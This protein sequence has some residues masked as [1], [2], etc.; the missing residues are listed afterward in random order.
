MPIFKYTALKNNR[1]F[2]DGVV[3]ALDY[4]EARNKIVNLGFTPT[5]VYSE[6]FIDDNV[7]KDIEPSQGDVKRLSLS[8]KISFTSELQT[9]LSSNI[10]ILE[11]LR[12]IEEHSPDKKICKICNTLSIGIKSGLTFAQS[13]DKYYSKVFGPVYIGLVK[14]GEDSGE[15]DVTLDRMLLMFRKQDSIKG[16]IV[17]ASIYPCILIVMML[18]LLILFAKF[19]F[20]AFAGAM[21]FN[22]AELPLMA[23]TLMGTMDFVNQFWWLLILGI[24]AFFGAFTSLLSNPKA[25]SKID[26][27]VLKIPAL[28]DF[29]QYINLSNF[30]TV[31]QISYDAGL[32][33]MSGMELA[34]KTV[35]NFNIKSKIYNAI[36]YLRGGKTLTE[37]FE[38]SQA[39]PPVFMSAIS[40]GEKSGTLGKMLKDVASTID[41]KV[42]MTLEALTRL[43]EPTV[44]VIMGGAVL[45]VAVAFYQAYIG[46][47]GSLF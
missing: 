11:A 10:P 1:E 20:P 21:A 22:G 42:D 28:S 3:E 7:Y 36:N 34:N 13:M 8:Q 9:L 29:I 35:G 16:K 47:L 12:V 24:G 19:V 45:F 37:A 6:D 33:I 30:M 38:R 18:G 44:I 39:I 46:M 26:N 40:A 14:T 15:L 25:K 5:K 27:F 2:V 41:K 17:N 32:P 31:L 43:F 23:K 4:R